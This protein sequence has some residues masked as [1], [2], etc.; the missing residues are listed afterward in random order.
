MSMSMQTETELPF[1]IPKPIEVCYRLLRF[2]ERILYR[3][4]IVYRGVLN[5]GSISELDYN[6][7]MESAFP[8]VEE[9]NHWVFEPVT[10]KISADREMLA[11]ILYDMLSK[12]ETRTVNLD[13]KG[14]V[15]Y[16]GTNIVDLHFF[17]FITRDGSRDLSN[18]RS[19]FHLLPKLGWIDIEEML[20][21]A[22]CEP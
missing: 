3:G 4:T 8:Q 16:T 22:I 18:Y 7:I 12:F 10:C 1:H 19:V 11:E 9:I 15:P 20:T 14:L 17:A 13:I 6:R 2:S 21:G 5:N